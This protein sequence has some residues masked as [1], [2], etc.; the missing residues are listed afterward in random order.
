MH[1]I[2]A[3]LQIMRNERAPVAQKADIAGIIKERGKVEICLTLARNMGMHR[4]IIGDGIES[5]NVAAKCERFHAVQ[6]SARMVSLAGAAPSSPRDL[7]LLQSC[8]SISR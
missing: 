5:V 6:S 3:R 7:C 8:D 4:R 1:L 2:A